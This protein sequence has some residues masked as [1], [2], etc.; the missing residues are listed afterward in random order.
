ML[1][2]ANVYIPGCRQHDP[3]PFG[4]A[5]PDGL[6]IYAANGW[7]SVQ[8]MRV[9]RPNFASGIQLGGTDAEIRSLSRDTMRISP[10]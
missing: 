5:Q 6:L 1:A 9:N 4:G 8:I 7:M 10:L 2:A 3:Y